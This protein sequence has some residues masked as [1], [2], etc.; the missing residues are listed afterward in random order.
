MMK[1]YDILAAELCTAPVAVSVSEQNCGTYTRYYLLFTHKDY[2]FPLR[3]ELRGTKREMSNLQFE[4]SLVQ[5]QIN[6]YEGLDSTVD[7]GSV[8]THMRRA[9]S[10][11]DHEV[12]K[13]VDL[14]TANGKRLDAFYENWFKR[15]DYMY[16]QSFVKACEITQEER[17]NSP[18]AYARSLC[19]HSN[20]SPP[21]GGWGAPTEQ[22]INKFGNLT[23]SKGDGSLH[24]TVYSANMTNEQ[25]SRLFALMD[26]FEGENEQG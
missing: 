5:E 12:Y 17:R 10:G 25:M 3:H 18:L 9:Y 2:N 26:S 16:Y 13:N 1:N 8:S 11:K 15:F 22:L 19:A 6:R 20:Y 7:Y 24:L 23:S 21:T 4:P 14:N